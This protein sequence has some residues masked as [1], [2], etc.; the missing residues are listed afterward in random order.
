MVPHD[1][2]TH[3]IKNNMNN[4]TIAKNLY[5]DS[6][7]ETPSSILDVVKNDFSSL[8][9]NQDI[10]T[11]I[12]TM[13]IEEDVAKYP[14]LESRYM[15]AIHEHIGEGTTGHVYSMSTV[16]G[17]VAVKFQNHSSRV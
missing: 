8:E 2:I 13:I 4:F 10:D 3:L 16:I 15:P 12:D 11:V 14:I 6:G 17:P 5:D 7:Y 1:V 9:R